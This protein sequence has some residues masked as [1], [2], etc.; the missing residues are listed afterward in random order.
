[1]V[2]LFVMNAR[3]IRH[4]YSEVS[5]KD[6]KHFHCFLFKEQHQESHVFQH[7]V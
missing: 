1:M 5:F 2:V 4:S 6:P 3:D 7:T